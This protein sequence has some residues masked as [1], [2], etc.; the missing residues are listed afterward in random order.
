MA[1]PFANVDPFGGP[2]PIEEADPFAGPAETIGAAPPDEEVERQ[3]WDWIP[4]SWRNLPGDIADAALGA[5][6]LEQPPTAASA[7]QAPPGPG[8][9]DPL[10]LP[11]S[12]RAGVDQALAAPQPSAEPGEHPWSAWLGNAAAQGAAVAGGVPI[13]GPAIAPLAGLAGAA[14]ALPT[15]PAPE[16]GRTYNRL[17]NVLALPDDQVAQVLR[18]A[19]DELFAQYQ[20]EHEAMRKGLIE[21]RVIQANTDA[22]R[23]AEADARAYETGLSARQRESDRLAAESQRLAQL[24]VDDNH[25]F[26]SGGTGRTI[27]SFIMGILGGFLAPK[28][29]GR[30]MGLEWIEREVDRDLEVQKFNIQNARTGLENQRGILADQVRQGRDLAEATRVAKIASYDRVITELNA[31]ASQ[32]DPRG[33][34]TLRAETT[35]R[36]VLAKKAVLE[37]K[38]L[39]ETQKHNEAAARLKLQRDQFEE[40]Q[41]RNSQLAEDAKAQR[42][43]D[44]ARHNLD[45]DKLKQDKDLEEKRIAAAAATKSQDR[46]DKVSDK[47]EKLTIGGVS[48]RDG[49][50]ALAATEKEGQELREQKAAVD[51]V[52]NFIGQMVRGIADHGGESGF[53][54]SNDWQRMKSTKASV[55][56]ALRVAN[57]M[58]TLDEGALKITEEMLGGVDPTSFWRDA[59]AGLINARDGLVTQ[60]NNNLRSQPKYD[61]DGYKPVDTTKLKGPVKTPDDE[62]GK[63]LLKDPYKFPSDRML[64][65]LGLEP[66][67]TSTDVATRLRAAGGMLPSQRAGL[68]RFASVAREAASKEDKEKALETLVQAANSSDVDAV[69]EYAST[70]LNNLGV[71]GEVRTATD[72]TV[73]EANE[74][75]AR[76]AQ[77]A[78]EL[79]QQLGPDELERRRREKAGR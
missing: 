30:N 29:G 10:G 76:A 3:P 74:G 24:R 12:A 68:D 14:Q 19:P 45:R 56:N 28:T 23:A 7:M 55:M 17:A 31:Q 40:Q 62:R 41:K 54:K 73:N 34:Q 26:S 61:G 8:M 52:N 71:A 70:L 16:P 48:N 32:F 75:Q 67:A 27:A 51:T 79:E 22:K 4:D 58:G 46:E 35:R 50:P 65:E 63:E 15:P 6:P 66:G 57:K 37:T 1:K 64:G 59:S 2:Q 36:E 9:V 21:A 72:E 42:D 13:I 43:I 33:T 38:H 60:F 44:W 77:E 20:Q 25:W 69:R 11:A 18:D 49:S 47:N 5:A 53:F 39:N 78:Q